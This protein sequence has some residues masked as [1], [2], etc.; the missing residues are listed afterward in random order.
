[1]SY[2]T[3][4]LVLLRY[5]ADYASPLCT[6]IIACRCYHT[7]RNLSRLSHH[8]DALAVSGRPCYVQKISPK[9]IPI[10]HYAALCNMIYATFSKCIL[11]RLMH[12]IHI[13]IISLYGHRTTACRAQC[14]LLSLARDAIVSRET[15]V[16]C[17]TFVPTLAYYSPAITT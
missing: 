3:F 4:G 16:S 17:E 14:C 11:C 6:S 12:I 5:L 7:V 15:I 9:I 2:L 13:I 10:P 8:V 1:M